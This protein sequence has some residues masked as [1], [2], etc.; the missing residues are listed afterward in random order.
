MTDAQAQ[1]ITNVVEQDVPR[2]GV[3]PAGIEPRW[4]GQTGS[5]GYVTKMFP[6]VSE[7]FI[8]R[9]ILALKRHGLPVRIYSVL[10]PIRDA[11]VHPEARDL[12]DAVSIL[13]EP[14]V[15]NLVT[16][17]SSVIA[18]LKTRPGS[19]TSE[20][21]RSLLRPGPRSFRRLFRAAHLAVQLRKDRVCHLHAA[22]AHTPASIARIASRLTGIPWS[23]GTHAKDIHLSRPDSLRKKVA[24]ARFTLACTASHEHLLETIGAP[25]E[26]DLAAPSVSLLYHGVDTKVFAPAGTA[27]RAEPDVSGACPVILSVGR[28]VCKKGFDVLVEAAAVLRQRGLCLRVDIVGEG[29]MRRELERQIRSLGLEGTVALRGTMLWPELVQAYR[30]A[31][32]VVLASRITAEGDRDG[33]PN[34]LAEAMA[35]AR[36]VVATNVAGISE[37][38]TDGETGILVPSNDP[39]AM[40]GA[41]EG[42]L[43][44]P[45]RR[46]RMGRRSREWIGQE[47]D[48]EDWGERVARRFRGALGIERILYLTADRGVPIRGSKGASVHVRSMVQA[49]KDLGVT[50]LVLTTRSGPEDGPSVDARAIETRTPRLIERLIHRA[51]LWVRGRAGLE[52]EA[53]RLLDNLALYWKGHRHS[54]AWHPD[55]LY[56]R[57]ALSCVAGSLLARRLKIPHFVEVNA[58]L[59]EEEARFR[60]GRVSWLTRWIEG[61][62]L[63]R[64]D[65][66]IVVSRA[67]ESH[68]R[69]LGV[70]PERILVLPNAF[71]PRIFHPHLDGRSV[72]RRL[73]PDGSF[74]VG[75]SGS[76]KPWHGVDHLLR[77]WAKVVQRMPSATL[78]IVGDG[79]CRDALEDLGR[80]LNVEHQVRFVGAVPHRSVGEYLAACDVLVAPYGPLEKFYFSPLKMAEYLAMGRPVVASALG[81]LQEEFD[82]THGVILVPPGDETS[83]ARA[84][85]DLGADPSRRECLGRAAASSAAWTWENVACLIL[86]E[87]EAARRQVWRWGT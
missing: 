72:R 40:A 27:E 49:L 71:D 36:P 86:T 43:K 38:V 64:A 22:W 32:C 24:S 50:A 29:P 15:S 11:R 35:C 75:F 2:D 25:E 80:N 78:L 7:T 34:T 77:A 82:E 63:R 52:I 41:I 73:Q 33:I 14:S 45:G 28:L 3:S 56:E 19:T 81:Q 53:L 46:L 9:E 13:P 16:S 23:M 6:R 1:M 30:N 62:T 21:V 84:L 70:S 8:L 18:C 74:L 76:L 26:K 69:N 55:L 61:W 66:V 5:L 20:I 42:L 44:D 79:P 57:A 39:A 65:R 85:I 58:P 54:R 17:L 59:S 10:A 87:G 47:F 60:A 37:L 12:L 83:L 4:L 51:V 31:L 67:L 48:A 68:V